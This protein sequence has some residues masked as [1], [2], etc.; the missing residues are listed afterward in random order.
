MA[1]RIA[2]LE[3]ADYQ[4]GKV[5]TDYVFVVD[6]LITSGITLAY[7]ARAI[8]KQNPRVKVYGLAPGKHAYLDDF[9]LDLQRS[10]NR[11]ILPMWD[12]LWYRYDKR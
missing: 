4:A 5:T 12:E 3:K 8:K 11:H 1:E 7:C 10:P 6:D 2:I 9:T